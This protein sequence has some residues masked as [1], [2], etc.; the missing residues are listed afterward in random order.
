[1]ATESI[2]ATRA[3]PSSDHARLALLSALAEA[4]DL[5]AAAT[6]LLSDILA[7]TD[8]KRAVLLR[9]D[10]TDEEL[11]LAGAVGFDEALP[12]DL[13]IGERTHPWMV[14]TLTLSPVKSE[15]PAR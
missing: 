5:A 15:G 10:T 4:P 11:V 3:Q 7:S 8:G 1:M 13:T 6:F 14:S 9:F 2:S 12:T